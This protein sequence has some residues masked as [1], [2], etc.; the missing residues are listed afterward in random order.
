MDVPHHC[1]ACGEIHGGSEQE[2]EQVK[3]AQINAKRDVEVARIQRG[4][5]KLAV[6]GAIEQTEIAAEAAVDEAVVENA[7]LEELTAPEPEPEPV[8]IVSNENDGGGMPEPEPAEELP[9][10]GPAP[11]A[12]KSGNPWW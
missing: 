12:S 8:V 9:D 11:E 5:T 7:I 6:E 10:P 1:S 4:E 2:S 3:L